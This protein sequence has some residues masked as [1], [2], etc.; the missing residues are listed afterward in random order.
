MASERMGALWKAGPLLRHI[1]LE[2]ALTRRL[3]SPGDGE[4][5]A[6]MLSPLSVMGYG[7]GVSLC[8]EITEHFIRDAAAG[9]EYIRGIID[10]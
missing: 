1:H 9:L 4:D 5:Y 10:N 3:P 6:R 7:G 2:N 8:G